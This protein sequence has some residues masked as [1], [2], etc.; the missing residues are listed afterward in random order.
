MPCCMLDRCQHKHFQV[1]E[2]EMLFWERA[3]RFGSCSPQKCVC[4]VGGGVHGDDDGVFV[5]SRG[6]C[7]VLLVVVLLLLCR[8]SS[9]GTWPPHCGDVDAW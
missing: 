4:G 1:L 8:F 6:V 5:E 3:C 7:V 2:P 9:G